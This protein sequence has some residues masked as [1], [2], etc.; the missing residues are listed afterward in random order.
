MNNIYLE[1]ALIMLQKVEERVKSEFQ[2]LERDQINWKPSESSWSIAECLDHLIA[3]NSLYFKVFEDIKNH[4]VTNSFFARIPGWSRLWS[5]MILK[6]VDPETK[7]KSKTFGVF[8]PR[9]SDYARTII[10]TF[11]NNQYRLVAYLHELDGYNDH[12]KMKVTSPVSAKVVL[13]L[14][15]AI[16]ILWKHEVRHLNQTKRLMAMDGFPK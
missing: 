14:Q 16:N 5:N 7:R 9:H 3:T 6:S 11:L 8:K 13:D 4:Q 15:S 2:H 10:D 12:H 1:H